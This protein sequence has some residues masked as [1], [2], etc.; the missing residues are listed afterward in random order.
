MTDA[1]EQQAAQPVDGAPAR[2]DH[3]EVLE[4]ERKLGLD[5]AALKR[6]FHA[7]N[8]KYHPD[9]FHGAPDEERRAALARSTRINDAFTCLKDRIR[10]LEHLLELEGLALESTTDQ[11]PPQFFELVMEANMAAEQAKGGDDSALPELKRL[12]AQVETELAGVYDRLS[13]AER[14]WDALIESGDGDRKALADRLNGL[15]KEILYLKRLERTIRGA[16][17]ELVAP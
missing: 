11:V 1:T 13:D 10:R 12:D 5:V 8:R 9:L 2:I 6:H 17:E 16:T 4:L 15:L 14:A 7:L 3:F